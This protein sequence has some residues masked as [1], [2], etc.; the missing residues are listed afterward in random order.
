MFKKFR[1][2]LVFFITVSILQAINPDSLIF[3]ID[4]TQSSKQQVEIQIQLAE[5]Y[6]TNNVEISLEYV[7][8]RYNN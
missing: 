8:S 5:Y 2:V 6:Q 1:L 3:L 7:I 4:T